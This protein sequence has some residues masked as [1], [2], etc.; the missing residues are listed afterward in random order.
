MSWVQIS[1]CWVPWVVD[2]KDEKNARDYYIVPA[3][4]CWKCHVDKTACWLSSQ[5]KRSVCPVV[6]TKGVV[7]KSRINESELKKKLEKVTKLRL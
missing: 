7:T 3:H 2:G 5:R 4:F 6:K 1:E